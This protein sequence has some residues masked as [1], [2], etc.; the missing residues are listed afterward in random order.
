VN[1]LLYRQSWQ[2][3]SVKLPK[4][5]ST[6]RRATVTVELLLFCPISSLFAV[7]W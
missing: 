2:R 7:H 3:G 6:T 4:R 1:T 5:H